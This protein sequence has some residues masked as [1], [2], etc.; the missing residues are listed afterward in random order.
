[1][2][3]NTLLW[4]SVPAIGV[5]TLLFNTGRVVFNMKTIKG[6]L[7][8]NLFVHMEF[9]LYKELKPVQSRILVHLLK[10]TKNYV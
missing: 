4:V 10:L 8:E 1:M 3:Q 9:L 2:S 5:G 7:R 6:V